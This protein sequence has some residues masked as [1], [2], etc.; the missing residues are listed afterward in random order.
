MRF[1][2]K[3]SIGYPLALILALFCSR[4]PAVQELEGVVDRSM[5]LETLRVYLN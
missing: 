3:R 2:F 4:A 5:P 1:V